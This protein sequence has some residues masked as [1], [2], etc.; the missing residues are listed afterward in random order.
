MGYG[1][2]HIRMIRDRAYIHLFEDEQPS[3]FPDLIPRYRVDRVE[4]S[5]RTPLGERRMT[6]LDA[7]AHML[8]LHE[9]TGLAVVVSAHDG[10]LIDAIGEKEHRRETGFERNP[11][12]SRGFLDG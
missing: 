9:H 5:V 7:Y 6:Y 4:G 11:T 12:V 1:M 8:T 2:L 10:T 3:L